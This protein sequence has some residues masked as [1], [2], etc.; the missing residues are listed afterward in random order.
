MLEFEYLFPLWWCYWGC[1]Q[2]CWRKYIT[3]GI[4]EF[5]VLIH[6]YFAL[7]ALCLLLHMW[8]LSFLFFLFWHQQLNILPWSL[9]SHHG[10][11]YS[12][13]CSLAGVQAACWSSWI[14]LFLLLLWEFQKRL[15]QVCDLE[16]EFTLSE[17]QFFSYLLVYCL[18]SFISIKYINNIYFTS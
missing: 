17:S 3:G 8:S 5:I 15:P 7:S 16:L 10:P 14:Q 6:S 18:F 11:S 1:V 2:P 4:S 12:V 13:P 9:L